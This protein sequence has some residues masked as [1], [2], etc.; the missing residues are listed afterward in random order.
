MTALMSRTLVAC[1]L[2]AAFVLAPVA[3]AHATE[4]VTF[5]LINGT[6][7][8]IMEFYAAPPS[9][10]TW[11]EDILGLDVLAP[12]ESVEITIDDSR[13][14]CLYD[15][16]AVFDDDSELVHEEVAVCDGEEYVYSDD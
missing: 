10:R 3:P 11:E 9:S 6:S 1:A 2:A 12:G 4:P 15:F 5:V 8:V 16:L 7:D 13:D 14:D